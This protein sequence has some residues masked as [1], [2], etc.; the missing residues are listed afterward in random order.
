MSAVAKHATHLHITMIPDVCIQGIVILW[1][2]VDG[3]IGQVAEQHGRLGID[4][5]L[6]QQQRVTKAAS[7]DWCQTCGLTSEHRVW[8]ALELCLVADFPKK[9][10]VLRTASC[11]DSLGRLLLQLVF[12]Q[13]GS[14]NRAVV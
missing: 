8:N 1:C 14:W 4:L 12:G 7:W 11:C 13:A 3:R 10:Q 2:A 9:I 5:V 6:R